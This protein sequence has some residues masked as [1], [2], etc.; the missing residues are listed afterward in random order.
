MSFTLFPGNKKGPLLAKR[1]VSH[2]KGLLSNQAVVDSNAGAEVPS[3]SSAVGAAT[4]RGDIGKVLCKSQIAVD[5]GVF[6]IAA[7]VEAA[8]AVDDAGQ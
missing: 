8:G 3:G 6:R 5:L 7:G 4:S 1:A 2:L